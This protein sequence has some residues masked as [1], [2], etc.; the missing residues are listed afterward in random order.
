MG[1]N[2]GNQLTC[3]ACLFWQGI[4]MT[5]TNLCDGASVDKVFSCDNKLDACKK[6]GPTQ[7]AFS[8]FVCCPS[9]AANFPCANL[10]DL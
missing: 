9:L 7:M 2:L 5:Y 6:Q 4:K 1:G 3:D 10:R 8:N